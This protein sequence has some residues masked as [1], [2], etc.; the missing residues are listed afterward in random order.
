MILIPRY[1]II[2]HGLKFS[3]CKHTVRPCNQDVLVIWD[4]WNMDDYER[5]KE[6]STFVEWVN[7]S[8]WR[9]YGFDDLTRSRY[10]DPAE[11]MDAVI[12][13]QYSLGV[14]DLFDLFHINVKF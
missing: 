3:R 2:K 11:A 12:G 7:L 6:T 14:V 13:F 1:D 4:F 5:W 10:N 8:Y 9:W